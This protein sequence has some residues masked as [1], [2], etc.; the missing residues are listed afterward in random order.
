MQQLFARLTRKKTWM[1]ITLGLFTA[2]LLFVV[3]WQLPKPQKKVVEVLL[4]PSDT[5]EKDSARAYFEST[6]HDLGLIAGSIYGTVSISPDK[7]YLV[8]SAEN[9]LTGA[10]TFYF[11]FEKKDAESVMQDYFFGVPAFSPNYIAF[12]YNGL[13]LKDTTTGDK[14]KIADNALVPERPMSSPD[15]LSLL[16]ST[17]D[18]LVLYTLATGA[19]QQIS[20]NENDKPLYWYNNSRGFIFS[21][22]SDDELYQLVEYTLKDST[23]NIFPFVIEGKPIQLRMDQN[24]KDAFLVTNDGESRFYLYLAFATGELTE[25][26]Q[27]DIYARGTVDYFHET[28]MKRQDCYA[29]LYSTSGETKTSFALPHA[30]GASCPYATL[31]SANEV[32]YE[33]RDAV[34]ASSMYRYEDGK[35]ETLL[36]ERT[37]EE[38]DFVFG[39]SSDRTLI[40]LSRGDHFVFY[41]L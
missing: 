10:E 4:A 34:G 17:K 41:S 3:V 11:D 19:K 5:A 30:D 9:T 22:T 35:S 26:G 39:L 7:R 18:G 32:L 25:V 36:F 13:F 21:R 14:I 15:G 28:I 37:K 31:I 6:L 1:Y 38:K 8:A 33:V 29:I 12:P 20:T 16:Y 23:E 24:E 40:A 2:T 27:E